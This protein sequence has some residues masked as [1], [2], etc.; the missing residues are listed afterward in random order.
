MPAVS[1]ANLLNPSG[2]EETRKNRNTDI[3]N[4]R[5]TKE[6]FFFNNINYFLII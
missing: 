1:Q 6:I 4:T 2:G 3:P 5:P